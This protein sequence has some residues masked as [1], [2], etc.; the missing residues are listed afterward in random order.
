M[1]RKKIYVLDT[2]ALL[3]SADCIYAY[4]KND[5][6]IPFKVL[7]EIDKHKKRQDGVGTQSRKTIRILL[8]RY[9]LLCF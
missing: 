7:E 2:S 3:T 6:V 9:E 8:L 5:I 1:S 4:G